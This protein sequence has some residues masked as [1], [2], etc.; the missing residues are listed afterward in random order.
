MKENLLKYISC[1]R[2]RNDVHQVIWICWQ[3]MYLRNFPFISTQVKCL[4]IL[5][6]ALHVM[7]RRSERLWLLRYRARASYF[8]LPREF[9]KTLKQFAAFDILS[10]VVKH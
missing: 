4:I 5:R 8:G 1:Q 7:P 2:K 9:N 6:A 10:K 3:L